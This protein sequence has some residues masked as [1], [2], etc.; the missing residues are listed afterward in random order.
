MWL[1]LDRDGVQGPGESGIPG[2][3]VDLVVPDAA[4]SVAHGFAVR[5]PTVLSV[6]SQATA[7]DGSFA[8]ASLPAGG[9][10]VLAHTPASL[11][12]TWDS[13]GVRD[14][15]MLVDLPVAGQ[16]HA[17]VGLVGDATVR[18]TGT[19]PSTVVLRWA[20]LDQVLRTSDDVLVVHQVSGATTVDGLPAGTW[21]IESQ[22]GT[23]L[24][25]TVTATSGRTVTAV[26]DSSLLSGASLASTGVS[27][28][29]LAALAAGL[30]LGGT[31]LITAS[32]PA[33]L[34]IRRRDG[35]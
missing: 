26:V 15:Q 3:S 20:G 8:F 29:L 11:G 25:S 4:V 14:G 5:M 21:V 9:Y 13:E 17:A 18:L 35:R 27:T 28:G 34:R 22:G 24:S 31:A 2:V 30:V 33:P 6:A 32:R 7:R 23:A 19:T 12:V 10:Q 16:G 1:D